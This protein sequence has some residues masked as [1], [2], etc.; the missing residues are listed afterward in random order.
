MEKEEYIEK[1]TS[2]Y[3][4]IRVYFFIYLWYYPLYIQ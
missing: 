1:D 2:L 4:F 3:D